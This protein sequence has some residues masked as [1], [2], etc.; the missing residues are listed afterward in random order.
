[1]ACVC[2]ED[3]MV[4]VPVK[5][6][7]RTGEKTTPIVQLAPAAR[8]VPQGLAGATGLKGGVTGKVSEFAAVPP[9]LVM[10][11]W[12]ALEWPGAT[13]GKASCAGVTLS[14]AGFWL[15]PVSGTLIAATPVVD[16]EITSAAML[17]PAAAGVKT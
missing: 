14:P 12:E 2:E 10:V 13:R 4:S 8:L 7:S 9:L 11:T 5:F 15:V 16:E 3:A 17:P 6:P 1:M